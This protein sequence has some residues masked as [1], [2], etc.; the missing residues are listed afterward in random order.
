MARTELQVGAQEGWKM[1]PPPLFAS[2]RMG[3]ESVLWWVVMRARES[4]LILF[5]SIHPRER[6][7]L[8]LIYSVARSRMTWP[9]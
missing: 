7:S 2:L 8:L 9:E 4:S 6:G 3:R 1:I 5:P